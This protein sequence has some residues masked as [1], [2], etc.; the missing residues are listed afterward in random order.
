M[1]SNMIAKRMLLAS[2]KKAT[3]GVM[4]NQ[5]TASTTMMMF[6]TLNSSI[7]ESTIQSQQS[8]SHGDHAHNSSTNWK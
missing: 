3:A 2:T 1:F 7:I 4:G 6:G 5:Y 8:N